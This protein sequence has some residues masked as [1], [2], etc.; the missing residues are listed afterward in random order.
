MTVYEVTA[1]PWAHGFELHVAGVGVT[2]CL[3]LDRAEETVRDYLACEGLA[4]AA[5]AEVRVNHRA[6]NPPQPE[7]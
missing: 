5:T 1:K 2:Q 7:G 3:G 4:D 6:E